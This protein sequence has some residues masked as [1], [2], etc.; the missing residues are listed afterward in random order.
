MVQQ[1][2]NSKALPAAP[3]TTKQV[4]P[5][6][7]VTTTKRLSTI[8]PGPST[9]AD[10]INSSRGDSSQN[11]PLASN[12]T[13]EEAIVAINGDRASAVP[14]STFANHIGNQMSEHPTNGHVGNSSL[15]AKH[16]APVVLGGAALSSGAAIFASTSNSTLDNVPTENGNA[17][18]VQ[19]YGQPVDST[20][21]QFDELV[22]PAET[23]IATGHPLPLEEVSLSLQRSL[24][25][26]TV[27]AHPDRRHDISSR[28]TAWIGPYIRSF[29][30]TSRSSSPLDTT[31]YTFPYTCFPHVIAAAFT[32]W[33]STINRRR[34]Q[35]RKFGQVSP[36][37]DFE[38]T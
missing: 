32:V 5:D 37:S 6:V 22:L 30:R 13:K 29:V 25:I 7:E 33:T 31:C 1:P 24:S 9:R 21:P 34:R 20:V 11:D 27:V 17:R 18:E 35:Q 19:E 10:G 26:L 12:P 15:D 4:A 3:V 8:E 16:L 38:R 14:Q 28:T 2:V 23:H 36:V